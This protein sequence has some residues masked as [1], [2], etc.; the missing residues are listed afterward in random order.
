[1]A[2]RSLVHALSETAKKQVRCYAF[3]LFLAAPVVR[4]E[5]TTHGLTGTHFLQKLSAE[6]LI[7]S[8]FRAFFYVIFVTFLPLYHFSQQ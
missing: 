5:L 6:R 4:L 1:M 2:N 3:L 8:P 7:F